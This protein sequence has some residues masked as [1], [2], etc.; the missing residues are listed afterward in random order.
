[1]DLDLLGSG[2]AGFLSDSIGDYPLQESAPNNTI[3]I[4]N[5]NEKVPIEDLKDTLFN[6]FEEYGDIIDVPLL[7]ARSSLNVTLE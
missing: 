3:Y 1:M 4:S 6:V 7:Q 2:G 5:L